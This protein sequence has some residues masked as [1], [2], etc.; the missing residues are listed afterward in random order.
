MA[1][2]SLDFTGA[3]VFVLFDG[4]LRCDAV[5]QAGVKDA[6]RDSDLPV[7]GL[8]AGLSRDDLLDQCALLSGQREE[9]GRR[10][11]GLC[12]A[13]FCRCWHFRHLYGQFR[14][15]RLRIVVGRF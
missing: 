14:T 2:I 15:L 6:L 7:V 5:L 10:L 4:L 13:I 3:G 11:R 12:A 8:A 1:T 9:H